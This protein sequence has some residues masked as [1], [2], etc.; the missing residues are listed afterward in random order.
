MVRLIGWKLCTLIK[1]IL[2]Y[3]FKNSSRSFLSVPD[4]RRTE[5]IA[6]DLLPKV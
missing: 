6:P 5:A 4:P 3:M 1:V 2:R